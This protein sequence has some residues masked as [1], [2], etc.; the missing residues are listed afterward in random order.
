MQY[1]DLTMGGMLFGYGIEGSSHKYGLFNDIVVSADIIVGTNEVVHC[2]ATENADLFR[3]L[4]WSYGGVGFA[5]AIE[6]SIIP[7]RKYCRLVYEPMS[8]VEDMVNRF[9]ELADSPN[10]PECM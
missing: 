5:V 6:L 2:S 1:D 3:A 7:V 4:P 9:T 10:P 8:C